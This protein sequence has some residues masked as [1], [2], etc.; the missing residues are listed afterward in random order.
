PEEV[1]WTLLQIARIQE[2]LG[3][4]AKEVDSS[5]IKALKYRPSRPEPY[6]YLASRSRLN[7]DFKKGYQIAKLASQLPLS[8]DTLFLEKWTYEGLQFELSVCAYYVGE[9]EECL[10]ICDNLIANKNLSENYRK[11]VVS[12]RK[13]AV[14]KLEEQKLIK[15]I[16]N[17][18]DDA[19]QAANSDKSD[20]NKI[21]Q[22]G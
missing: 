14:E 3:Y 21:L 16:D 1:F 7:D 10:K 4:E 2:N 18:F 20:A 8:N 5:Y 22:R 12:N 13:F 11:Y 9:Y 17:L 15:T 6:Y 19:T